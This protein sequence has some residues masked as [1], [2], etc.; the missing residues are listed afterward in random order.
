MGCGEFGVRDPGWRTPSRASPRATN[1]QAFG[2]KS[3]TPSQLGATQELRG[4]RISSCIST[5]ERLRRHVRTGQLL[6]HRR[7]AWNTHSS[8]R[9]ACE[10]VAWGEARLCVRHPKIDGESG[11][12]A[13]GVQ[14]ASVTTCVRA[15]R[16]RSR[17]AGRSEHQSPSRSPTCTPSVC[18]VSS[19]SS[20]G[21]ARRA[22]LH[23]GLLTSSPPG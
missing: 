5:G 22:G 11:P 1:Y 21:G 9:E 19:P 6:R 10:S 8:G 16:H 20:R 15:P 3:S 13:V 4:G 2:L 7:K 23:P 17:C 14:V 12:H 18:G